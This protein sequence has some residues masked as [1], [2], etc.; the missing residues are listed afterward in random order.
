MTNST[1]VSSS[2]KN[3]CE[4]APKNNLESPTKTQSIQALSSFNIDYSQ[5]YYYDSILR[6]AYVPSV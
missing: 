2:G 6:Q 5:S 3:V 4:A 1:E